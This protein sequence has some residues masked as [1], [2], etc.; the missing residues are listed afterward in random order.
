MTF[1]KY[2]ERA[3]NAIM[4]HRAYALFYPMGAGKTLVALT[5]AE[6]LL[7]EEYEVARVLVI[8]PK[9]VAE[10]TWTRE[11]SKWEHLRGLTVTKVLGTAAQRTKAAESDAD[12]YVIN[13]ENVA[14]LVGQYRKSWRWDMIIIDELSNFKSPSSARFKALSKVALEARHIVGLTGTPRPNG[15]LDLW[16]QIYLL[17]GGERLERT[18]GEYRGRYFRQGRELAPHVYEWIPRKGS[19]EAITEKIHDIVTSLSADEYP[20]L[21]GRTDAIFGVTLDSKA[22][23]TYDTLHDTA[24]L[25]E[26][27]ITAESAAKLMNKLLQASGGAVYDDEGEA[28]TIHTAKLEALAEILEA[29]DTPVMVMYGYKHEAARLKEYFKDYKPRELSNAQDIA[30]WNAGKIRLLIA[31]PASVGYGLNLQDGGHTLVWYTLPWSLELYQQAT[32]RLYRQG[33]TQ[34]VVVQHLIAVDT[35]DERVYAALQRKDLGQ[36]A[37]LEALGYRHMSEIIS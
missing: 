30:D 18:F 31:H 16:A 34:H 20:E 1:H 4:R 36:A 28:H 6:K 35:V 26:E 17:D 3:I 8:A 9:K 23:K 5:A 27:G 21:P 14:W 13:R 37:L 10:D 2:Q 12:I 24:V 32:A 22:R 25:S 19:D 29:E 7:H 33:Q 11:A 15:L